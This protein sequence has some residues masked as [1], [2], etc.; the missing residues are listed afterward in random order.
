MR[1]LN[2][3]HGDAMNAFYSFQLW[4]ASLRRAVRPET[5][6]QVLACRQP[7]SPLSQCILSL[8]LALPHAIEL[9]VASDLQPPGGAPLALR[10]RVE[11][12]LP[13][14]L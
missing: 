12:D 2:A 7:A 13:R 5:E 3:I 6:G 10:A 14:T 1:W 4:L 8:L 9:M 11:T